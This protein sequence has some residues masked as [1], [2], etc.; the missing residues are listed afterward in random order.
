MTVPAIVTPTHD[1]PKQGVRCFLHPGFFSGLPLPREKVPSPRVHEQFGLHLAS[2]FL[3][4]ITLHSNKQTFCLNSLNVSC[5]LS[6]PSPCRFRFLHLQQC[7]PD[8]NSSSSFKFQ[9]GPLCSQE[10]SP[11]LLSPNLV[12]VPPLGPPTSHLPP[13]LGVPHT[14]V[15]F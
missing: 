8:L 9:L 14:A 2:F 12:T 10:G 15:C 11:A 1:R 6:L 3:F 13:P 4:L 5:L 7:G